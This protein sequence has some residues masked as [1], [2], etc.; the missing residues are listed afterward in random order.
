MWIDDLLFGIRDV[1]NAA[2]IELPTSGAVQFGAGFVLTY[3]VTKRRI[4]VD[5]D[6]SVITA[7]HVLAALAGATSPVDVAGQAVTDVASVALSNGATVYN[8]EAT[9][10]DD[11][12]N[13]L[14]LSVPFP[15]G[16]SAWVKIAVIGKGTGGLYKA[17]G[18]WFL[19]N[20]AGTL[21]NKNSAAVGTDVNEIGAVGLVRGL[22]SGN[23]VFVVRG[24]AET[25]VAWRAFVQV[26]VL[27]H[28]YLTGA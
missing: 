9:T 23:L 28:R 26:L 7:Q 18:E 27:E 24:V 6:G 2:G 11:T 16:T 4:K 15:A 12:T 25:E 21:E 20:N 17:S 8:T 1:I 3:D 19:L 22:D 10:T 5:F 13:A 14:V